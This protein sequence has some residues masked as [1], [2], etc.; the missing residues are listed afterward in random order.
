MRRKRKKCFL[1]RE[2]F[3]VDY[4]D[5]KLLQRFATEGFRLL[6]ARVTSL[7]RKNQNRVSLAMRR[8]RFLALIPYGGRQLFDS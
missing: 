2:G 7:S 3:E 5:V 4:K 8:A 6:P 1:D